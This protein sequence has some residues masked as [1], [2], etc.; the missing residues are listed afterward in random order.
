[1]PDD[2]TSPASGSQES[3][4]YDPSDSFSAKLGNFFRLA[5][6]RITDDGVR[7]WIKARDDLNEEA[8]CAKCEKHRDYLLQYSRLTRDGGPSSITTGLKAASRSHHTLHA[9]EHQ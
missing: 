5:L 8:D 4:G 2:T 3:T 9:A 6:G 1:M 7:Q